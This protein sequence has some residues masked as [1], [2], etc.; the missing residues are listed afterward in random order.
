MPETKPCRICRRWFRPEPRAGKRQ[1]VCSSEA[2]QRERLRRNAS[3][4]RAANADRLEADRL[5]EKLRV[6]PD[7]PSEVLAADPLA[8]I[9]PLAARIAV[10]LK[11]QV[12]LEEY[13]KV[14]LRGPRIAVAPKTSL[15]RRGGAEVP[16]SGRRIDTDPTRRPP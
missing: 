7:P 1:R 14:A 13:V 5:R 15:E 16:G 12:V 4:W 8:K 10:G 9:D 11:A 3:A 2:C 6:A